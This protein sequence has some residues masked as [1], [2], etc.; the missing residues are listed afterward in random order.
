MEVANEKCVYKLSKCRCE[1][2]YPLC[3]NRVFAMAHLP[4]EKLNELKQLIHSHL[5]QTDVHSKIKHCLDDSFK[6]EGDARSGGVDENT[7]LN[8]LRERGVINDVMRTLKFEGISSREGERERIPD[9][10][11]Q[12]RNVDDSSQPKGQ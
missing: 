9:H 10:T 4:T 3:F 1:F 7:V 6:G 8:I 5:N 11:A 12:K 2:Y